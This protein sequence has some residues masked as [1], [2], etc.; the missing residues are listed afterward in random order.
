MASKSKFWSAAS[1]SDSDGGFDGPDDERPGKAPAPAAARGGAAM[2]YE[3]SSDDETAKRVVRSARDKRF[4]EMRELLASMKNHSKI[5]DFNNLHSDFEK[6]QK[7]ISRMSGI[8][9]KE[10]IPKIYFACLI[11]LD[12]AT[13]AASADPALKKKMSTTNSKALNSLKSKV[14]KLIKTHEDKVNDARAHPVQSDEEENANDD[15]DDDKNSTSS[16]DDLAAPPAADFGKRTTK[17]WGS[18]DDSDDNSDDG[19]KPDHTGPAP[20][21]WFLQHD[22]KKPSGAGKTKVRGQTRGPRPEKD[23]AQT[24]AG[25][26]EATGDREALTDQAIDQ[27][28][29]EII[30]D[31]GRKKVVAKEQIDSLVK[32]FTQTKTPS[33]QVEVLLLLIS[34]R[35]DVNLNMIS[36][37]PVDEWKMVIEN[38]SELLSILQSNPGLVVAGEDDVAQL[39]HTDDED[40]P[41]TSA[42]PSSTT[43][44]SASTTPAGATA[45][46][47]SADASNAEAPEPLMVGGNV[48]AF[49]ERLG[50]EFTKS[51]KFTDHHTPEYITRLQD[52]SKL[53]ELAARVQEYYATIGFVKKAARVAAVRVEHMYY[54]LHLTVNPDEVERK[55]T[56]FRALIKQLCS[57][58]YRHADDRTKVRTL[59]CQAYHLALHDHYPEARDLLLMSHIQDSIG[60]QDIHT[61]VL[62]NRA[63]VQLGLSAFRAG[64]IVD[65]FTCLQ[66]IFSGGRIKELLAQGTSARFAEKNPEQEKLE[67]RR[68]MPHHLHINIEL[69]ECVHLLCA[70]LLEVPNMAAN[71]LDTKRKIISRQFRRSL[72]HA[73][74]QEFSGPPENTREYVMASARAL[75]TGDWRK[76]LGLVVDLPIWNLPSWTVPAQRIA[77]KAML[78]R[79]FQQEGLRTFL[80]SFSQ[81]YQSMDL[82]HLASMFELTHK[83]IHTLVSKM[84]VSQELNASWDSSSSCIIMHRVEPTKLQNLALQFAEKV[85]V[86]VENNEKIYSGVYGFGKFDNKNQKD[87]WPEYPQRTANSG[88]TFPP[89]RQPHPSSGYRSALHR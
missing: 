7:Q 57:Y 18:D 34:T 56:E 35:F 39:R 68:Q 11:H 5:N 72:D 45:A 14:R 78:K 63:L 50:D 84:M 44:A 64:I 48:L 49:V 6:L 22:N 61:Q 31:R 69:L 60:V 83:Q 21:P 20:S 82:D 85:S 15:D 43:T 17:K 26:G 24:G 89:R 76:A 74:R 25:K 65:A 30:R 10:G 77:V 33:K 67:R 52:E 46:S 66:D 32:I 19:E 47:T 12:D 16:N 36:Y 28:L 13:T 73:Q 53:L 9:A 80:F 4:D 87:R 40:A 71:Q 62:F 2:F 79:K 23:A 8:I 59:L 81:Y 41:A 70:A 27:R 38:I 1:D 54:K 51:L 75:A 42:V 3:S 55:T 29:K 58:V 88:R 86:F 37:T